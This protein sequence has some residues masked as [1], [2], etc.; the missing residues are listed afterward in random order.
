LQK[1][2]ESLRELFKGLA[3]RILKE[4]TP[5]DALAACL[6]RISGRTEGPSRR[7]LINC[8]EGFATMLLSSKWEGRCCTFWNAYNTLQSVCP[9]LD[10]SHVCDVKT[11][12]NRM[13]VVFDM[14]E[15][16][17]D[18]LLKAF[19]ATPP[20]G[21]SLVIADALPELQEKPQ[22]FNSSYGR[23]GRG[24]GYSDRNGG[25]R[26]GDRN[27]GGRWAGGGGRGG[28]YGGRSSGGRGGG[29]RGRR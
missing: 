16:M 28:S 1:I 6:A 9:E 12:A 15:N 7:S 24:G 2:P 19:K 25:G 29:F 10:N 27:G 11:L 14:T 8:R 4:M 5:T 13:G 18:P 21:Y 23:G 20:P 3:A 22:P 26:F 17:V